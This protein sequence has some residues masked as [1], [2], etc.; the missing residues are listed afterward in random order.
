MCRCFLSYG[1]ISGSVY[2][3]FYHPKWNFISLKMTEIVLYMQTVTRNWLHTE[4][5]LF[6]FAQNE[7]SWL[8]TLS[9]K[10]TSLQAFLLEANIRWISKLDSLLFHGEKILECL[11]IVKLFNLIF[12]CLNNLFIHLALLLLKSMAF[13]FYKSWLILNF[14]LR[15]DQLFLLGIVSSRSSCPEVF[16]KKGILRNSAKFTG[17]H[18]CQSPSFNNVT[19]SGLQKK[20]VTQVFS[21]EFCKISKNTFFYKI[22]P[23]AVFSV[24]SFIFWYAS[25][26][27]WGIL[28]E[29]HRHIRRITWKCKFKLTN[30]YLTEAINWLLILSKHLNQT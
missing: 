20:A 30:I 2:M 8:H 3:I 27:S 4:M 9:K 1:F 22:R 23:V 14:S 16:C 5:K 25:S 21:C 6:H 28:H 18:L 24:L 29:G 26:S 19:G 13:P 11:N 7:I 17:K 15:F 12:K 10:I